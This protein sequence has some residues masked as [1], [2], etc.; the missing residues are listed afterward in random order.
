MK[1][2]LGIPIIVFS[3]L[4][5]GCA[6]SES[7]ASKSSFEYPEGCEEPREPPQVLN[8]REAMNYHQYPA[9]LRRKKS[10]VE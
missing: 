1:T 8:M 6:S 5:S 3:I 2:L 9:E 4:L 10:W 7:T